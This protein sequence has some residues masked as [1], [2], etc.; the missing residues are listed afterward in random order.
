MIIQSILFLAMQAR[1][2]TIDCSLQ[3]EK[4]VKAG[5]SQPGELIGLTPEGH[6]IFVVKF[7]DQGGDAAYEL[8]VEASSCSLISKRLLWSE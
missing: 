2:Q 3:A 1:A 5:Y 8:I 4:Y 6:L 7:N